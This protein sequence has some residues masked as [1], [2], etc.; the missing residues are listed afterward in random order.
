MIY[1]DKILGKL[2]SLFASFTDLRSLHGGKTDKSTA[3]VKTVYGITWQ[4]KGPFLTR[5]FAPLPSA[6]GLLSSFG[7]CLDSC[8][9]R[10]NQFDSFRL[11]PSST[12]CVTLVPSSPIPEIKTLKALANAK[13]WFSSLTCTSWHSWMWFIVVVILSEFGSEQ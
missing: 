4:K 7:Q 12:R 11:L 9:S 3:A 2:P 6:W 8:G 10:S 13:R 1:K 5:A